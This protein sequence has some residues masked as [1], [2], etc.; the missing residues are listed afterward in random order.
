MMCPRLARPLA[1]FGVACGLLAGVLPCP[2]QAGTL[3]PAIAEARLMA[4]AEMALVDLGYDLAAP[5]GFPDAQS[6]AALAR[7]KNGLGLPGEAPLTPELADA[8][9]AMAAARRATLLALAERRRSA[10]E[11]LVLAAEEYAVLARIDR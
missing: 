8:V 1:A 10:E 3:D 4:R 2:A 11:R 9:A 7:I 5:D 6:D